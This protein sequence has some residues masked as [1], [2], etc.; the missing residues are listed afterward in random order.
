[1]HKQV[2]FKPHTCIN[3]LG[4]HFSIVTVSVPVKLTE[5]Q[6]PYFN[7][8]I[9][10]ACLFKAFKRTVAFS[11]VKMNFGTRDRKDLNRVPRNCPPYRDEL[12]YPEVCLFY[13]FQICSASSSLSKTVIQSFFSR[14]LKYFCKKFPRPF[15]RLSFKIISKGKVSQHFKISAVSC[16][17]TNTLNIRRSDTFLACCNSLI[18]RNSLS[19][20]KTF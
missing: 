15:D 5:Y 3:I 20:E 16:C 4:F 18:R 19:Q 14:N 13:F 2:F 8:S 9:T 7:D 17:F 12:F 10:F 6:I 1:M 11:S